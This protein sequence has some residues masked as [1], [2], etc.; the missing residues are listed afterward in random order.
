VHTSVPLLH[1]LPKSWHRAILAHLGFSFYSQEANLNL[2]DKQD[3]H[4]IGKALAGYSV[5][6]HTLGLLGWPSNLLIVGRRLPCGKAL[7]PTQ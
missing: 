6:V 4:S 7:R 1:W 3:F 2:M 5:E